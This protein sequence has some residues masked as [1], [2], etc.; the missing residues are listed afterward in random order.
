[1]GAPMPPAA[2]LSALLAVVAAPGDTDALARALRR[3]LS[4]PDRCRAMGRAA[5]ERIAAWNFDADLDG[6]RAALASAYVA[7]STRR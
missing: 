4:D 5:A 3:V 7:P 1:M 6:L 2:T